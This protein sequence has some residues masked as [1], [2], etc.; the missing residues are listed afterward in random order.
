MSTTSAREYRL[1]LTNSDGT[2]IQADVLVTVDW[3]MALD[4]A[5]TAMRNKTRKSSIG[6]KAITAKVIGD[7]TELPPK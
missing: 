1:T 4:V 5:A 6:A 2:R 3:E 7:I